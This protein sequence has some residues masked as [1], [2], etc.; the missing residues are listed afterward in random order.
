MIIAVFV[1]NGVKIDFRRVTCD[2]A[3]IWDVCKVLHIARVLHAGAGSVAAA[4][5]CILHVM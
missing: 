1:K 5:F 2:Y 3:R 4:K